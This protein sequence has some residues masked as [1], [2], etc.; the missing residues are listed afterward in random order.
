MV[1]IMV[2]DENDNPPTFSQTEF[3]LSLQVTIHYLREHSTNSR[4]PGFLVVV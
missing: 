2:A 4:G 3:R 1:S